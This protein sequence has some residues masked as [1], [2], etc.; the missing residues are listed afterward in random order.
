VLP[1]MIN[2]RKWLD[3]FK[4]EIENAKEIEG[5]LAM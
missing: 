4:R 3:G 1:A 2:H 5:E